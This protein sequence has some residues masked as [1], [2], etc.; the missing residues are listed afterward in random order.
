MPLSAELYREIYEQAQAY[1]GTFMERLCFYMVNFAACIEKS[2]LKLCQE[3]VR[4][5]VDPEFA[6]SPQRKASC[7]WIYVPCGGYWRTA[8]RGAN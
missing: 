8:L 5:T 4:N 3:W 1:E 6:G 2:S 7:A